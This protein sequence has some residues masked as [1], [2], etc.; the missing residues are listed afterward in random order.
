MANILSIHCSVLN[1]FGRLGILIITEEAEIITNIFQSPSIFS[2]K[3][4]V[5]EILNWHKDN[6]LSLISN[7]NIDSIVVKKTETISIRGKNSDVFKLYLEG[8]MLSLAGS[9]GIQ[10]SHFG[11]NSIKAILKN[12]KIY[13]LSLEEILESFE[14]KLDSFPTNNDSREVIKEVLLAAIAFNI[15]LQE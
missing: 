4:D 12:T 1:G 7:Y 2:F 3:R 6:I 15:Y 13:D 9:L 5:G 14:I 11:K 8:V 10:N